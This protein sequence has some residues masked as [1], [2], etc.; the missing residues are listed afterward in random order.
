MLKHCS[1]LTDGCW[2]CECEENY[3]HAKIREGEC[4]ICHAKAEE[5]PDSH[6]NEVLELPESF[7]MTAEDYVENVGYCP[8]CFHSE[9]DQDND[10]NCTCLA[11]GRE[12][13]DMILFTGYSFAESNEYHEVE[14]V[15]QVEKLSEQVRILREALAGLLPWIEHE[16]PGP[17]EVGESFRADLSAARASLEATK[18]GA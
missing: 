14:V 13:R 8:F 10:N 1:P 5:A 11:C 2:D 9:V 12:W 6:V 15:D 7:R 18:E 3:I 17:G 16:E 4:P